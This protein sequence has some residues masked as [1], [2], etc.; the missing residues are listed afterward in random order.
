MDNDN[1]TEA[2]LLSVREWLGDGCF[3][4]YF[5]CV[6]PLLGLLEG[7]TR[8][9]D[10]LEAVEASLKKKGALLLAKKYAKLKQ[11]AGFQGPSGPWLITSGGCHK[12]WCQDKTMMFCGCSSCRA[13]SERDIRTIV[14]GQAPAHPVED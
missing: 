3:A 12:E 6:G 11:E 5:I 8:M 2:R 7:R 13:G 1:Y 4:D 14:R 10:D 9:A